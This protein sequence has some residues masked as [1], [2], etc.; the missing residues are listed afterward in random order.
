MRFSFVALAVALA[1]PSL[2]RAEGYYLGLGT[3]GG[4]AIEGSLASRY[5][6][7]DGSGRLMLGRRWSNDFALEAAYFGSDLVGVGDGA[8]YA[9]SALGLDLKYH[10]PL[11]FGFELYV[12]GGVHLDRINRIHGSDD[13]VATGRGYGYGVGLL[14]ALRALKVVEAGVWLDLAKQVTTYDF[15]DGSA[16]AETR[17]L[18]VG[19]SIGTGI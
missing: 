19:F 2:A 14:W 8:A 9:S 12:K 15:A 17:V 5:D 7:A 13:D 11:I 16:D 18:M 3:G 6:G 4:P 10:L 1:L